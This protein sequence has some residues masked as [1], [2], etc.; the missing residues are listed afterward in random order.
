[1]GARGPASSFKREYCDTARRISML[2]ATL[3]EL[4]G[5]LGVCR[6]TV[7]NWMRDFPEFRAAV[8][9]GK[10]T[11]DAHV[12]EKLY[13]RAI[14]YDRPAVRI[15]ANPDGP[16]IEVPYT[17]HHAPDTAAAIFWLR[18]RRRADWR[19]QVEHHHST[20]E[21][22]LAVLEAARLRARDGRRS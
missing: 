18:N 7:H 1:M 6:A 12:A 5:V 2:G 13:Q 16:P 10:L 9:E 17:H 15:F 3:D 11:A 8:E 20:S 19:E 14:G 4:A 22:L 21:D